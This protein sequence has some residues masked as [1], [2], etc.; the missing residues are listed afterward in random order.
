MVDID[1]L[2]DMWSIC[3]EYIPVKDREAVADHIINDLMDSGITDSDLKDFY[4]RD[5]YLR[6]AAESYGLTR[7]DHDDIDD[8]L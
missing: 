6:D 3:K 5:R 4:S 1:V 2:Y 7:N 8:D